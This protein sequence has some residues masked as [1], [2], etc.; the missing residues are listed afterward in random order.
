MGSIEPDQ[1]LQNSQEYQALTAYLSSSPKSLNDSLESFCKP[2]EDTYMNP[3]SASEV[4]SQLWRTWKAVIA[5]ATQTPHDSAGRQ[6][7]ADFVLELQNRPV[8]ES[9]GNTCK[10][11]DAV[12]WKDLPIFGPSMREA[13]NSAATESSPTSARTAWLNLNAFTATLVATTHSRNNPTP[14]GSDFSLYAIWTIRMALEDSGDESEQ[15]LDQT[16]R[17]AAAAWFAYAAPALWDL[18]CQGKEFEGKIAKQ[19]MAMQ[20]KEWR[21]FGKDRWAVWEER[22]GRCAEEGLVAKA[23]E[24]IK[25]AKEG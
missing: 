11:W 20:G 23:K 6:K 10:V 19:G 18:S 1:E 7:L 16:A 5:A 22:L 4:E 12:V 3:Q 25:A 24:A 14:P 15:K 8:L 13:W 2:T 21:G 9:N 17:Q